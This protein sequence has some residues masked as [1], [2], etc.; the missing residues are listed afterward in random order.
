M[1]KYFRVFVGVCIALVVTVTPVLATDARGGDAAKDQWTATQANQSE[2]QANQYTAAA[3]PNAAEVTPTDA[4]TKSVAQHVEVTGAGSVSELDGPTEA[5]EEAAKNELKRTLG[6]AV[7]ETVNAVIEQPAESID[8]ALEQNARKVNADSE[9]PVEGTATIP[10]NAATTPAPAATMPAPAATSPTAETVQPSASPTDLAEPTVEPT[11]AKTEPVIAEPTQN[12]T[13]ASAVGPAATTP[14]SEPYVPTPEATRTTTSQTSA[15][16]SATAATKAGSSPETHATTAAPAASPTPTPTATKAPTAS[17][18]PTPTATKAPT[19]SPTPTPTATKAVEPSASPAP[20]PSPTD[21]EPSDDSGWN[22]GYIISDAKMFNG[23]AM[24]QFQ[25]QQFLDLK[26]RSCISNRAKG[27]ECLKDYTVATPT[28]TSTICKEFQG[29]ASDTAASIIAKAGA[30]CN[31]NPQVLLVMLQKEQ[32]L[33]TASGSKLTLAAYSHALGFGC[34]DNGGCDSR[35]ATFAQ[36]VYAAAEGLVR[37]GT[38]PIASW[39]KRA[40]GTYNIAYNPNPMCGSAPVTIKNRATAALYNYTP[41]QPNA[42]AIEDLYGS[43][44]GCPSYGNRNFWTL[45]QSWFGS[46]Y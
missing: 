43:G 40:G 13:T 38:E 11:P 35:Y 5:T 1:E 14:A 3:T 8:A 10:G 21:E 36:Q 4:E 34:P 31:V 15:T 39:L 45:F 24:S 25:I 30:A 26:G 42:A 6:A 7:T 22:A 28:M 16:P 37:Y 46:T 20:A 12:V 41:Y 27:V 23:S 32:G 2:T 17:P 33:V 9:N 44:D 29:S 19:A 18:T